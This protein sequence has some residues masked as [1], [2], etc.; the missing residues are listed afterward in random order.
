M[1]ADG[2]QSS[3]NTAGAPY[4]TGYCDAQCPADVKFI[5]GEANSKGRCEG[6]CGGQWCPVT[7]A[8]NQMSQVRRHRQLRGSD[9]VLL[10]KLL[11]FTSRKKSSKSHE[12][13]VEL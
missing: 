10:Q 4:G 11:R 8:L 9:H 12:P 13:S 6:A 2:D 7:S 5:A 3:T 1:P